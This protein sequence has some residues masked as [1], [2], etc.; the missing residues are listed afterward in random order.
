MPHDADPN[1]RYSISDILPLLPSTEPAGAFTGFK[2]GLM[3]TRA[4]YL[5]TKVNKQ[6]IIEPEYIEQ[7]NIKPENIKQDH[8]PEMPSS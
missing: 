2:S 8:Q 4:E 7:E 1:R 5:G 3:P 6:E